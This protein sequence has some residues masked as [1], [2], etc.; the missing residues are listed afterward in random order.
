M[1]L[2]AAD[3]GLLNLI[4]P[5]AKMVSG[6][7]MDRARNSPLGQFV[8]SQMQKDDKDLNEF[9]TTTGFDPRRDLHGV[10][11]AGIDPKQHGT[12]LVVMRGSF[13]LTRIRAAE[14]A[15]SLRA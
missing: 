7:D 1:S 4:M 15:D 6:V 12:G 2:P 3:N 5:G 13:D 10:M 8:L 14:D 9:I 11:M